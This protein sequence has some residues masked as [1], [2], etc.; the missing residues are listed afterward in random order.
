M[1][2]LFNA[3]EFASR[4][5]EVMRARGIT[6]SDLS[7]ATGIRYLTVLRIVNGG[8]K[9]RPKKL[10]MICGVLNTNEQWLLTGEGKA[11][12][13][14]QSTHNG[15]VVE[16]PLYL[17]SALETS[18][19]PVS[20]KTFDYLI[21]DSDAEIADYFAV[22]ID[23]DFGFVLPDNTVLVLKKTKAIDFK[24]GQI[25]FKRGKDSLSLIR[26]SI[27]KERVVHTPII[28][29]PLM[30]NDNRAEQSALLEAAIYL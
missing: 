1:D 19:N 5:Q 4:L 27:R 2:A 25:V 3:N 29:F 20:T 22:Q 10:E 16:M 18:Y 15:L 13:E 9:R 12:K 24:N 8:I 21:Q 7:R 28:F 11:E 23:E 14:G 30:P 26:I 17:W 6:S